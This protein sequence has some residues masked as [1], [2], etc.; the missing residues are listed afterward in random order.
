MWLND[1][2]GK[3]VLDI[4]SGSG[5]FSLAAYQLG[6]KKVVSFDIDI[7]SVKC[8]RDIKS[9]FGNPKNWIVLKGNILD[10]KFIKS[11]GTFDIVYSWGVLHH[12]G[13]MWQAI[14]NSMSLV[15]KNGYYYI[16]IYNKTNSLFGSSFWWHFKKNYNFLPTFGK[17][18]CKFGFHS[19][20]V[21]KDIITLKSP[22]KRYKNY[23]KKR[24]MNWGNDIN[25]WLGGFPYEYASIYELI[26]FVG[27]TNPSFQINNVKDVNYIACNW[28]LFKKCDV[29]R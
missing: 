27:K 16:A 12:T 10:K 4:G 14:K 5:L 13:S 2:K 1:F 29:Q 7:D 17:S 6:A 18:I 19:A 21:L 28:L 22:F 8:T 3:T 15:A 9:K 11:L 25:D 26:T 23:K 20:Y 24:G